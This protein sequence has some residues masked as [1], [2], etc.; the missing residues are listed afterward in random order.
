MPKQKKKIPLGAIDLGYSN[1]KFSTGVLEDKSLHSSLFQSV[2]NNAS[3]DDMQAGYHGERN[4]VIVEVDGSLYE[5]GPDAWITK[6]T[7][8][9]L[10]EDYV[11]HPHYSALMKGALHYMDVDEIELL[12][13][14]LPVSMNALAPFLKEKWTGDISINQNKSVKVN[15]VIVLDQ[16]YGSLIYFSSL[17][18][19]NYELVQGRNNLV[20]D[21]GHFTNDWLY[22][23]GL[24]KDKTRSGSH[25]S[26]ISAILAQVALKFGM[27]NGIANYRDFA[28]MDSGL[29]TG[30]AELYGQKVP[31]Q[32]YYPMVADLAQRPISAMQNQVGNDCREVHNMFLTGG[33]PFLFRP[34]LQET[35]PRHNLIEIPNSVFANVF[36]YI[37][38]GDA[39]LKAKNGASA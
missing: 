2:V 26:G 19:E 29:R 3:V 30:E 14:G 9:I 15:E 17:S 24:K 34:G 22:S 28:N 7:D 10:H 33:A 38:R 8:R 23:V 12:V 16:P 6:N 35:F 37:L 39:Y 1:T 25:N 13:L 18:K 5:V 20:I 31:M 4:T 32:D 21:P 11:R 36:G 27:D